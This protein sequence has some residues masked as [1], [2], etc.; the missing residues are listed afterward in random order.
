[1]FED[2]IAQARTQF[3]RIKKEWGNAGQD[4]RSAIRRVWT[5]QLENMWDAAREGASENKLWEN[6]V[7]WA[8]GSSY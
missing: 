2:S 6:F 3:S 4:E 1:M 8:N 5:E 7:E